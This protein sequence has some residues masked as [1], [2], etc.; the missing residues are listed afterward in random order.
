[1]IDYEQMVFSINYFIEKL[2][3]CPILQ[4]SRNR[5]KEII[6]LPQTPASQK[7]L[8]EENCCYENERGD[9][10]KPYWQYVPRLQKQTRSCCKSLFSIYS[11]SDYPSNFVWINQIQKT[12]LCVWARFGPV[13]RATFEQFRRYQQ[14]LTF[15]N[16]QNR[17]NIFSLLTSKNYKLTNG[18]RSNRVIYI[19]IASRV[20]HFKYLDFQET[21]KMTKSEP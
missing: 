16:S 1:M 14:N 11:D 15:P 19:Y 6:Q 8:S 12:F 21:L 9:H 17:R 2:F 3:S 20:V 18:K 7:T 4:H 5:Y 10:S 13:E